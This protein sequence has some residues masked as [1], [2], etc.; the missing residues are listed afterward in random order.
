M[1]KLD[2][3]DYSKIQIGNAQNFTAIKMRVFDRK[4]QHEI[5][6]SD[7]PGVQAQISNHG[8]ILYYTDNTAPIIQRFV[9]APMPEG[10][11]SSWDKYA[12]RD[13]TETP[14]MNN[15][16][17]LGKTVIK[18]GVST[19][20]EKDY[21]AKIMDKGDHIEYSDA[22][23]SSTFGKQ[24]LPKTGVHADWNAHYVAKDGKAD[25]F[26]SSKKGTY[27]F[28]YMDKDGA[29]NYW[30]FTPMASGFQSTKTGSYRGLMYYPELR[31][32][33]TFD[34]LPTK[35]LIC[36]DLAK[37]YDAATN[38]RN[39]E[40][41]KAAFTGIAIALGG[42]STAT[43]S[44]A[45]QT[46]YSGYYAGEYWSGTGTTQYSGYA[47][48]YDYSYLAVGAVNLINSA[49]KSNAPVQNIRAAIEQQQ[50]DFNL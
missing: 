32:W 26:K 20:D 48:T 38:A 7:D 11:H 40:L 49:F 46:A 42:Y 27:R 4:R 33:Y 21:V 44:G 9:L 5:S 50:C 23:Y 8:N 19:S 29:L 16:I 39:Q 30:D 31:K 12:I 15:Y 28:S 36:F 13:L 18:D 22:D 35:K 3:A 6:S 41:T 25:I 37:A 24:A 43:F 34:Y 2:S 14:D 17:A 10:T 1:K 47:Q 45:A